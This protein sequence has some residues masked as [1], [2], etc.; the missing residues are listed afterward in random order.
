[1]S[2]MA[3]GVN[4]CPLCTVPRAI[5]TGITGQTREGITIGRME[6]AHHCRAHRLW[7]GIKHR[8]APFGPLPEDDDLVPFLAQIAIAE[9]CQLSAATSC[10]R[11]DL[12]QSVITQACVAGLIDALECRF[13]VL[14]SE[15]LGP[16][17]GLYLAALDS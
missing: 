12:Q 3:W 5:H 4:A 15:G 9:R 13:H 17:V 14:G 1:M 11:R 6:V 7:Q 2:A 16:G 10:D 8:L